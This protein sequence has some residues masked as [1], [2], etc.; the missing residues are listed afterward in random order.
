MKR[1]IASVALLTTLTCLAGNGSSG[2]GGAAVCRD[3]DGRIISSQLL[4]L[5]EA[6]YIHGY[7]I[8][9]SNV[10]FK[11][12]IQ[13]KLQKIQRIPFYFHLINEAVEDI[14]KRFNFLPIG[15]SL[16]APQDSGE[17][18][19][20]LVPDGCRLEGVGFYN[21][22]GVLRVAKNTFDHFNETN[23]AAFI[24]HE[25]LYHLY[26]S[27]HPYI[28][29]MT[30]FEARKMNAMLFSNNVT[31]E[32]AINFFRDSINQLPFN[33]SGDGQIKQAIIPY[34]AGPVNKFRIRVEPK[35]TNLTP[36]ILTVSCG[37][38]DLNS[39]RASITVASNQESI[40]VQE[41]EFDDS[42][43]HHLRISEK[44]Y[45]ELSGVKID[46]FYN[47]RK[48]LTEINSRLKTRLQ[49]AREQ[50]PKY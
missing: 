5:F 21:T 24:L 9:V 15:I 25:A 28:L 47:N 7:Q 10:N 46:V 27:F 17:N 6:P 14:G 29:P 44:E 1:L 50:N 11:D 2:G 49:L 22:D 35:K 26:R 20:V 16:N 36:Y 34:S 33:E 38:Y 39:T 3:Q 31:D 37:G 45:R 13:K 18:D 40:E 32:E 42:N 12:Q 23:K 8:E 48:V 19:A 43:C 30:S 4:D 41:L